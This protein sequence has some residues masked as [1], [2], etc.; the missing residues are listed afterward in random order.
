MEMLTE[1]EVVSIGHGCSLCTQFGG[2][3][4]SVIMLVALSEGFSG[5]ISH[6]CSLCV[7]PSLWSEPIGHGCSLWVL[8]GE[9]D[10]GDCVSVL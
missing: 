8:R 6:D 3:E 9:G 1:G 10:I 5:H 4:P 7:R 2:G